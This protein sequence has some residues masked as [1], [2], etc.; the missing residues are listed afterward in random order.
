MNSL[1]DFQ[2]T[3]SYIRIINSNFKRF[4]VCGS[5]LANRWN[6]PLGN[7]TFFKY[8]Y[9]NQRLVMHSKQKNFEGYE[10]ENQRPNYFYAPQNESFSCPIDNYSSHPFAKCFSIE[11]ENS[12]FSD[13]QF[14]RLT[15]DQVPVH[16]KEEDDEFFFRFRGAVLNIR[17][18]KGPILLRN[19]TFE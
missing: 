3:A 15:T 16:N 4:G 2:M 6:P 7:L 17:Q 9:P 13:L 19:N 10:K 11:I 12:L 14:G 8:S 5:I 18:M 1:V